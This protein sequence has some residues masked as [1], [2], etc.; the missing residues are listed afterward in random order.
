[1]NNGLSGFSL[2]VGALASGTNSVYAGVFG[3]VYVSSD[4]GASWNGPGTGLPAF[5]GVSPV[6]ADGTDL[7]AGAG[8]GIYHSTDNGATWSDASTGLPP[9]GGS[10][11]AVTRSGSTLFVGLFSTSSIYKSSDNGAHWS[12]SSNG[13][14]A[15]SWCAALL[16]V[17]QF[18]FAGFNY[19]GN[20]LADGVY[21][22]SDDGA[23]WSPVS[24]GLPGLSTVN[25][26]AVVG[27]DLYG[28]YLGV[29]KR[30][31]S[32]ITGVRETGAPLPAKFA[33]E[34]N[35]PNPFNPSTNFN[36][37]IS[38]PGFVNLTVYDLL[39]R[40]ISALVRQPL[41]RGSYSVT[42]DASGEPSGVYYYRLQSGNLREVRKMILSK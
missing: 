38:E 19:S 36:F 16:S 34:Q 21:R 15:G 5:G 13:V 39:G 3:G 33:L 40:E 32:Q 41:R 42:W 4:N 22:S 31:L 18:V 24:D 25:Q 14:P 6:Y 1:M 8:S 23:N 29:W 30:P 10:V 12:P 35:Y 7:W 11:T 20:G 17:G 2:L 37:Q 28:S 27:T 9:F 26:L